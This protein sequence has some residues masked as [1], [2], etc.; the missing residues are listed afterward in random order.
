MR[1]ASKSQM[2]LPCLPRK[3][4]DLSE[5]DIAS[6]VRSQKDFLKGQRALFEPF[7]TFFEIRQVFHFS[8]PVQKTSNMKKSGECSAEVLID[9]ASVTAFFDMLEK[10]D[11]H[12]R[13]IVVRG[14]SIPGLEEVCHLYFGNEG[15]ITATPA[16]SGALLFDF[17]RESEAALARI[18]AVA[19][20]KPRERR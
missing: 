9:R 8:S 5:E 19:G 12:L 6:A 15:G 16:A 14:K 2:S 1:P 10:S 18:P 4:K 11:E 17:A 7:F 20:K 13:E 3:K